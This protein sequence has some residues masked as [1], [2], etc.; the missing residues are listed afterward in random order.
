M[1][2]HNDYISDKEDEEIKA[3]V[4]Q[5]VPNHDKLTVMQIMKEIQAMNVSE[6]HKM[7]AMFLIGLS[8]SLTKDILPTNMTVISTLN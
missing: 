3:I 8:A 5:Y 2:K 4:D 6:K 1:N 7:G